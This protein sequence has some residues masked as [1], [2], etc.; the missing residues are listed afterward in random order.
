MCGECCRH[1]DLISELSEFDS[2]NGI[3]IHLKE[4]ICD[5]YENRPDLCRVDRMYEKQFS[6]EY[7]WDEFCKLNEFVCK[8]LQTIGV[9]K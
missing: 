7:T 6:K 2:G 3:C 8:Q 4:N 5:I 1:I 9:P